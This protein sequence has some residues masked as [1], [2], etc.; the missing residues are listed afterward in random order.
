MSGNDLTANRILVKNRSLWDEFDSQYTKIRQGKEAASEKLWL[1]V[2]ELEEWVRERTAK[3]PITPMEL[4]NIF[5]AA[6]RKMHAILTA[7]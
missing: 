6:R 1:T 3:R 5:V 7:W 4:D 2:K